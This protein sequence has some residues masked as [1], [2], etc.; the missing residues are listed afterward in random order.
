LKSSHLG[1]NP[2][3]AEDNFSLQLQTLDW[4]FHFVAKSDLEGLEYSLQTLMPSD[5]GSTL[6]PNEL[7]DVVCYLM[8]AANA[9]TSPAETREKSLKRNRP[10]SARS[11][12][13][14]RSKG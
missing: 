13:R 11:K 9:S 4:T 12:S 1:W 8:S 10:R 2:V 3:V 5:Y 6:G 7:N 14:V